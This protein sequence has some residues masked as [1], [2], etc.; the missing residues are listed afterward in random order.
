MGD[1]W[2][3]GGWPETVPTR[4]LLTAPAQRNRQIMERSTAQWY[5]IMPPCIDSGRRLV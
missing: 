5:H 4:S 2:L 1:V 3:Y